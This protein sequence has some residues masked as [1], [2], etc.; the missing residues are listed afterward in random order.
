MIGQA[1]LPL[2]ST[3]WECFIPGDPVAKGRPRAC[4]VKGRARMY[5]PGKTAEW[6]AR[7]VAYLQRA[8]TRPA[9]TGPVRIEIHALFA[10]PKRLV[11]KRKPMPRCPHLAKPDADNVAKTVADALEKAGVIENDSRAWELVV[12]KE[13]A[14]GGEQPGVRVVVSWE[15]EEVV[16]D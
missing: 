6:E 2:T 5:T 8:W 16:D 10:R 12:R 15:G 7:A 14:A 13:H 11:W 9:L 3:C 4:V 1:T